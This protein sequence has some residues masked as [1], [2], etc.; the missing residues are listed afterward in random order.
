[1]DV[2]NILTPKQAYL[3]QDC[4]KCDLPLETIESQMAGLGKKCQETLFKLFEKDLSLNSGKVVSGDTLFNFLAIMAAPENLNLDPCLHSLAAK[5]AEIAINLGKQPDLTVNDIDYQFIL[6]CFAIS[7]NCFDE[8][9][10]NIIHNALT[11]LG[12]T[13]FIQFANGDF[14]KGTAVLGYDSESKR[15]TVNATIRRSAAEVF[16][17]LPKMARPD[18]TFWT[19]DPCHAQIVLDTILLRFLPDQVTIRD[20][21]Y[22]GLTYGKSL[23]EK[24]VDPDR[25]SVEDFDVVMV[26]IPLMQDGQYIYDYKVSQSIYTF[27]MDASPEGMQA[28]YNKEKSLAGCSA[29]LIKK[30]KLDRLRDFMSKLEMKIYKAEKRSRGKKK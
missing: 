29:Y 12:F 24:D 21:F 10:K 30:D 7:R 1:M 28:S 19:F 20:E 9:I 23:P 3:V 13:H 2:T 6:D 14:C 17:L 27:L 16:N 25:F 15:I 18:K 11:E 8:R 22:E 5:V 26:K 4:T